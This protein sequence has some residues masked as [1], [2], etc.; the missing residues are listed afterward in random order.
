[1][2][3]IDEDGDGSGDEDVG[4]DMNGDT[5][6]GIAGVDDDADGAIDE[7]NPDDDDEDGSVDEDWYDPVV[8]YLAGSVL[9]KRTPVPWDTNGDSAVDGADFIESDIA[10]YVTRFRVERVVHGG[11]GDLIEL[12][13]ELTSPG[14]GEMVSLQTRVR[15]GG[16]L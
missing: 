16:A 6:G 9:K 2:D 7:G 4:S 8:F 10:Q 3:A 5:T 13:L 12:T 1:M 14:S 11:T 15:L